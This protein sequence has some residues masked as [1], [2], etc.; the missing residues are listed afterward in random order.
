M[1]KVLILSCLFGLCII[2]LHSQGED[3]KQMSMTLNQCVAKALEGNLD[4]AVQSFNPEINEAAISQAREIFLPDFRV[5]FSNEN[6]DNLTSWGVEGINYT[7]KQHMYTFSLNQKFVTGADIALR[8]LNYT[9]KTTKNLTAVNPQYYNRF[10]L[11]ITQPLLKNM[12]PKITRYEIDRAEN[13]RDISKIELDSTVLQKVYEV[14]EAYWNLVYAMENLKVR[15]LSLVQSREQ[16]KSSREA[17]RIGAGSALD[18]LKAKTEVAQAEDQ[19][20]AARSQVEMYEDQLKEILNLDT[21]GFEGQMSIIPADEPKIDRPDISFEQA[22]KLAMERNPDVARLDKQ[23]ENSSLDIS[24]H[25]NQLLPQLDL[26]FSLWY[27]GQGGIRSFYLNNN[28]FTGIV[29]DQEERSRIDAF[30]DILDRKYQNWQVR[31]NLSIPLENLFSRARL[32]QARLEKDQITA[33]KERLEKTVYF[34]LLEVFKDLN[35]NEKRIGSTARYR[36]MVEKK[37]EAE[38][39]RYRLGLTGPE[40]LFSYQRELAQAK[41]DEIQAVTTYKKSV[42]KLEKILGISLDKKGLLYRKK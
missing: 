5:E 13:Q 29:V 34:D 1:K 27:L 37:L 28:P 6:L 3:P 7:T 4:I 21:L 30:K 15:E 32:T 8:Y 9:T 40:W 39:Q 31:L 12:G 25:K 20:L 26:N 18:V 11:E 16:H 17:A 14:E 24:Y 23:I 38:H 33:E 36:E 41:A 10:T 42:A 2:S 22:L 19:V 35:N